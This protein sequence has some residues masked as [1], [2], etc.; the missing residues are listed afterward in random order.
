MNGYALGILLKSDDRRVIRDSL[1]IDARLGYQFMPQ[2]GIHL[3]GGY[4]ISSVK[5]T[6]SRIDAD[7]FRIGPGIK[8]FQPVGR[9]FIFFA[10]T[11]LGFGRVSLSGPTTVSQGKNGFASGLD[12]GLT[13]KILPWL[14]VSPYMGFHFISGDVNGQRAISVW[15]YPG[16]MANFNF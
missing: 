13:W 2:L 16:A 15:Y 5:G 1:W 7:Y 3:D 12:F 4:F 6:T 11:M 9:R 10:S 8:L 14:G